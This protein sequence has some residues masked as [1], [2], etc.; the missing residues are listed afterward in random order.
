MS[1]GHSSSRLVRSH[2]APHPSPP[3]PP[4]HPYAWLLETN[5][6]GLPVVSV[7][8]GLPTAPPLA[9]QGL[10]HGVAAA[11]AAQGVSLRLLI[12]RPPHSLSS[13]AAHKSDG[14]APLLPS[15]ALTGNAWPA[16]HAS[17]DGKSHLFWGIE[18]GTS[19]AAAVG[20]ATTRTARVDD[21]LAS[22]LGADGAATVR[23]NP[24]N[25]A[26]RLAMMATSAAATRVL[27]HA[28]PPTPLT[29]FIPARLAA[30]LTWLIT[31]TAAGA[32]ATH[33]ALLAGD[34]VVAACPAWSALP[35]ALT[36]ALAARVAV[37][38]S[39][40]AARHVSGGGGGGGGSVS[41]GSAA[42]APPP[43]GAAAPAADVGATSG[44]HILPL[45]LPAG[46]GGKWGVPAT[47]VCV[48]M[49]LL[50]AGTGRAAVTLACGTP[51]AGSRVFLVLVRP[52]ARS[53]RPASAAPTTAAAGPFA[54]AR[55][56][57]Q[58]RAA[59]DA[60]PAGYVAGAVAALSLLAAAAPLLHLTS[61]G[62]GSG[63]RLPS[64]EEALAIALPSRSLRSVY[65]TDAPPAVVAA[66]AAAAAVVPGRHGGGALPGVRHR[67]LTAA[68]VIGSRSGAAV[69]SVPHR[70]FLQP[71]HAPAATAWL[72]AAAAT[73]TGVPTH[74]CDDVPTGA[75]PVHID[76]WRPG[77][78]GAATHGSVDRASFLVASRAPSPS[79][80]P[81]PVTSIVV[82]LE[83]EPV[84]VHARQAE[85][86][87][88]ASSLEAF[89]TT[90]VAT[91]ADQLAPGAAAIDFS[92]MPSPAGWAG[93][94]TSSCA[95]IIHS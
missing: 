48:P 5:D 52:A 18:S 67:Y 7:R 6:A 29:P 20:D 68:A 89:A 56:E 49:A 2:S 14:T 21:I 72:R 87:V 33:A 34:A 65:L 94:A 53:A 60:A 8:A 80:P 63:W 58:M 31:A 50:S 41:G 38:A 78:P 64:A 55:V 95:S 26:L 3:P 22:A 37:L 59:L 61:A 17:P 11:A 42:P 46:G 12:G 1:R 84:T 15:T 16:L 39:G 35:P 4:P 71:D 57:A 92:I 69:F 47:A 93:S 73:A 82:L 36:A 45:W 19:C 43:A 51:A 62:V 85:P 30:C 83:A 90:L 86:P 32:R 66:A 75:I 88:A 70:A 54:P 44:G 27:S 79:A 10:V 74:G 76:L 91:V 23:A 81:L 28:P 9:L 13:T 25:R 40:A 77:V 24:N